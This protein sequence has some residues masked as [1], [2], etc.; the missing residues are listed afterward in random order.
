[1]G[2]HTASLATRSAH[3]NHD[4]DDDARSID[5][6]ASRLN[7]RREAEPARHLDLQA[8]SRGEQL[9]Q[10]ELARF[11]FDLVRL[12]PQ[13]RLCRRE[14]AELDLRRAAAGPGDCRVESPQRLVRRDEDEHAQALPDDAVDDV[15]E[16]GK[17]LACLFLGVGR[18]TPAGSRSLR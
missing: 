1:V 11:R 6:R 9:G 3:D 10:R 12:E 13:R 7:S 15:E 8:G 4:F 18:A 16:P 17:P 5:V 2:S 14:G